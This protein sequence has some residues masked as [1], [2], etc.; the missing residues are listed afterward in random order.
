MNIERQSVPVRGHA[1]HPFAGGGD[2]SRR[3]R[4]RWGPAPFRR[5]ENILSTPLGWGSGS[6]SL[7]RRAVMARQTARIGI[8][9]RARNVAV[10]QNE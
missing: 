3:A 8:L 6:L 10:D 7:P 9:A 1:A 2:S 4:R 5:V